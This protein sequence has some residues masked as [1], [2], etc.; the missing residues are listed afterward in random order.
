MDNAYKQITG[1][2]KKE[3]EEMQNKWIADCKRKEEE[4]KKLIPKLTE[5]WI[6]K[7]KRILA[8]DKWDYQ[9]Q[10]VPIRLND[11]YKGMEL[12]CCLD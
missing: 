3:Y 9:T 2:T 7:G 4:F 6:E 10:I 5:E 11:L 12:G 1:K 8:K